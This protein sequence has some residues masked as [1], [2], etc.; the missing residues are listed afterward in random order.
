MFFAKSVKCKIC[1]FHAYRQY[2]YRRWHNVDC[3]ETFYGITWIKNWWICSDCKP[4]VEGGLRFHDIDGYQ[5][6]FTKKWP[7]IKR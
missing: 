6:R 4:T 3:F 7:F 5:Y 2:V 1:K